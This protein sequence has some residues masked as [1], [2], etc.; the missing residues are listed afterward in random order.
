[1]ID[2]ILSLIYLSFG[3]YC[4][5]L[6]SRN[7]VTSATIIYNWSILSHQTQIYYYNNSISTLANIYNTKMI[8][9]GLLYLLITLINAVVLFYSLKLFC[10]L[11][12]KWR[13]TL[14]SKFSDIRASRYIEVKISLLRCT[15]DYKLLNSLMQISL[16]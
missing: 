16:Y 14:R 6:S 8:V 12:E 7:T 5:V 9:T 1:M 13:P 2:F 11:E 10:N 3:I 15:K 4:M